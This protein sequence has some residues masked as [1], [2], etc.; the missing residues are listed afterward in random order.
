MKYSN[1]VLPGFYPDPSVCRVGDDYYLVNSTFEYFP[2]VPVSHSKDLV[3]WKL[4][5]YCISRNSQLKFTTG[6]QQNRTGIYA[7]SIRFHEGRYYMITTNVTFGGEQDGT[8]YVWTED[9]T[10]EW[11]EPVFLGTEG[12]DPSLFF[13]EDGKSYYVGT[14]EKIYISEV[15]LKQGKIVGERVDI[16]G[17]TGGSYPEGPHIYKKDGWYYLM[18]SEGGTER[19]HMLTMAR[20]RDVKGPY[21][22]CPFNP[23]LTNRS[24]ARP[25]ESAGHAD[26]VQDKEGNWWAICLGTRTFSYPPK[27]NLG[28]ETMLVPV[29][30]S[31]EWPILG[32]YGTLEKE[33]EVQGIPNIELK[34]YDDIAEFRDDFIEP[35]MNLSW[36]YIYNPNWEAYQT[37]EGEL[38]LF[39]YENNLSDPYANTWV[40]RRQQ[41]H[42]SKSKV[43]MEF[44]PASEEEEAGL[45]IFMNNCH[46]YDSAIIMKDGIRKLIFRRRIGSLVKIENEIVIEDSKVVLELESNTNYYTFYYTLSGG[47]RKLLGKGETQYLTTEVGG[48]FTGNYV[49]LYATGNGKKSRAP[50][51]FRHFVY[52]GER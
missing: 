12:I 3:N 21:E 46:H 9:P 43:E 35:K 23:I 38:R 42:N 22:E 17:G 36:N 16:W 2:G 27:H 33:I 10:G 44:E 47:K 8:F 13:D 7:P 5:G 26:L 20:S 50:G 40:G 45:T 30:W 32:K 41:H 14:H 28:R 1:P 29:D 25:I 39:G 48:S 6:Q 49:G 19:S 31:G 4:V 18:I 51:I 24:L 37:G 52:V 11:S 15:D 34:T